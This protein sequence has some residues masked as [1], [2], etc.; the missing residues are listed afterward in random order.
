MDIGVSDDKR[1]AWP[2]EE[3]RIYAQFL[4]SCRT[5]RPG[6]KEVSLEDEELVE[7]VVEGE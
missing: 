4:E 7:G 1:K 6:L 3:S 2:V 5:G